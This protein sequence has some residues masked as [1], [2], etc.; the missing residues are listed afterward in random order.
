MDAI[1]LLMDEIRRESALRETIVGATSPTA[2]FL[3]EQLRQE[4]LIRS[5]LDLPQS[6]HSMLGM[7]ETAEERINGMFR[8]AQEAIDALGFQ[9]QFLHHL[10]DD[11]M[12]SSTIIDSANEQLDAI[13]RMFEY[14]DA[15]AS[16]VERHRNEAL[17][18]LDQFTTLEN[19]IGLDVRSDVTDDI[20]SAL[21]S[22]IAEAYV[23]IDP[24]DEDRATV[25][26]RLEVT[27]SEAKAKGH[28]LS[29]ALRTFL[30][31][32]A[33]L[34]VGIQITID[35]AR[36]LVF[37]ISSIAGPA[38]ED[39]THYHYHYHAPEPQ[40]ELPDGPITP[41]PEDGEQLK[42]NDSQ[43]TESINDRPV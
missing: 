43:K 7:V 4:E 39:S 1:S 19:A 22:V 10:Q 23:G 30:L 9:R 25:L 18:F 34:L 13:A 31:E 5:A 36:I 11:R 21:D 15:I 20:F 17:H 2:A 24:S 42:P 37:T 14:P 6:V 35:I 26:E 33:P 12:L 41:E 38:S 32:N 29:L 27:L 40:H 3:E 8:P 28:S 16:A